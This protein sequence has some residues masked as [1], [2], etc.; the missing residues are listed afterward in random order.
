MSEEGGGTNLAA[1]R[2]KKQQILNQEQ[3]PSKFQNQQGGQ[4][5]YS[6]QTQNIP[7]Q[8]QYPQQIIPQQQTQNI[9]QQIIPQQ[10]QYSQ[11]N[12]P[13]QQYPQQQQQQSI[14]ENIPQIIP[15]PEKKSSFKINK[16]NTTSS[17]TTKSFFGEFIENDKAFKLSALV[18]FI[19]I[20]LN[21]KIIWSQI[22]KLPFMGSIEPS[23]LALII[24]SILAGVIFY[25]VSVF[26][27]KVS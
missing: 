18:I 11:Q 17:S 16:S 10:Q 22:Q 5:N 8:Q 27:I 19:F 4:I 9:P 2:A 24:N 13:Q 25:V 21:H 14:P 20:L 1:L 6:Q 7:Q 26:L 3:A 12:I 23:I 15:A